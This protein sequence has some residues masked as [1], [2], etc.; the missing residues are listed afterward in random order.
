MKYSLMRV[1]HWMPLG[2]NVCDS[3]WKLILFFENGLRGT[4]V[5]CIILSAFSVDPASL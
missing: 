1:L 5:A 3:D 4:V 2:A